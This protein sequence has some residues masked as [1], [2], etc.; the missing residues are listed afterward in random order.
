LTDGGCQV[1][2]DEVPAPP[3]L[4]CSFCARSS[5]VV[6]RLVG[7]PGVHI[8]DAC[9]EICEQILAGQPAP[10]FTPW[11]D[12]GDDEVLA[13]LARAARSV[14]QVQS[15]VQEQVDRLRRRGVTWARIGEAL[16]VSRQAAWER[17]GSAG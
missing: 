7:G 11:D 9:V 14:A 8:C 1:Y 12:L 10:E 6:D 15:A 13:Q 16:G 2:L 17:F 5:D 3:A 4:F